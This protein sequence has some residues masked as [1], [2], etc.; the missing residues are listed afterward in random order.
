LRA[1][2]ALHHLLLYR[3]HKSDPANQFRG[4]GKF[5]EDVGRKVFRR[6]VEEQLKEL[7]GAY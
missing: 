4:V 6:A 5:S 7:L 2:E 3:F 1:R